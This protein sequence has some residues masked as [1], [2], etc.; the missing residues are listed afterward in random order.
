MGQVVGYDVDMAR[1]LWSGSISFGLV[2][3]PVK[4]YPSTRDHA[5]HFNQLDKKSGARVRYEKISEKTGKKLE[6]D[7]IELGFEVARGTYVTTTQDELEELRPRT[8]RTIDITDFVELAQIDPVYFDHTYWLAPAGEGAEQGY[9]LL[10]VAT[11]DADRAGIGRVVMRNKQ[12]LAALRP[13]DG[14]LAMS[15][16]RFADE[17]VPVSDVPGI[18]VGTG[19]V[20]PGQ[21]KLALQIIESLATDWD[22]ARYRDTYT[23]E[24]KA[25]LAKKAKGEDIV[26]ESEP[27]PSAKVVDLMEALQA[28]LDAGKKRPRKAAAKKTTKARRSA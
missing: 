23:D 6:A 19:K 9:R 17:V 16:L 26:T 1:S 21:R 22:P 2:N 8:T 14:A 28:S 15:T 11:A 25:M 4:A 13:K 24:L 10:A 20:D 27:E 7:D 3:I 12:Y 5:V 18:P